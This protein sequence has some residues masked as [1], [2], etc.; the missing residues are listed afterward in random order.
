MRVKTFPVLALLAAALPG[1]CHSQTISFDALYAKT[2]PARALGN[3][4][5]L[6]LPAPAAPARTAGTE[7][8]YEGL[9]KAPLWKAQG[10]AAASD[11]SSGFSEAKYQGNRNLCNAFA[12]SSLAEYLVWRR[13]GTKPDLSEE[14]LYYNTKLK[15][16]DTPDL[17]GYKSQPGLPGY[18]TVLA[19]DGGMVAESDWP[20]AAQLPQHT[21]VPPLTDPDLGIPPAG[22]FQKTLPYGFRP[23]AMRR[24]DMKYF[25]AAE[26]RPVVMNLMLYFGNIDNATGRLTQPTD[27]Q[28]AQCRSA[29]DNCGGHVVLITG[30]DPRAKEYIFRNSWGARWGA[31]GYGRVPEAYVQQDCEAC[32]FLSGIAGYD[33]AT[34]TQMINASYGWSAEL[35]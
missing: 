26:G 33:A 11:L 15:F 29:G 19:L 24:S 4:P 28:R 21:P 30:Y 22:V 17:N 12:A 3:I 10:Q 6:E 27:A 8:A 32:G 35:K 25:L 13:D 5:G 34:K 20:F 7:L 31:A 23:Q 16:T 1:L 18:G 9:L 14:F 2:S